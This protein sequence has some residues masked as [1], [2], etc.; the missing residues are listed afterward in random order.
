[1]VYFNDSLV[2]YLVDQLKGISTKDEICL[3]L[4][5]WFEQTTTVE[6]IDVETQTTNN[7]CDI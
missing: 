1:M 4:D 2:D 5:E 3:W 6:V 7:T